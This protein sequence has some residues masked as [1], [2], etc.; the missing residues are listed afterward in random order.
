MSHLLLLY[1]D[2]PHLL[3]SKDKKDFT[4]WNPITMIP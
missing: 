1:S 3:Y 2:Y 4:P